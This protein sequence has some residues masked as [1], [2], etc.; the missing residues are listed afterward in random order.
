MDLPLVLLMLFGATTVALE[1]AS[2]IRSA[3]SRRAKAAAPAPALP[4]PGIGAVHEPTRV[5]GAVAPPPGHVV[6]PGMANFVDPAA[7]TMRRPDGLPQASDAP[8]TAAELAE[9]WAWVDQLRW[10]DP[11]GPTLAGVTTSLGGQRD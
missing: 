9:R 2:M 3:R 7:A 6:Q 4:V 11:D 1:A 10:A 8:E 5:R